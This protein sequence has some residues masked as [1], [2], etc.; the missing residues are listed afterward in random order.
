MKILRIFHPD[1]W[2]TKENGHKFLYRKNK[3]TSSVE[4][5]DMSQIGIKSIRKFMDCFPKPYYDYNEWERNDKG[6]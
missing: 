6:R 3:I 2:T 1:W 4:K 5:I